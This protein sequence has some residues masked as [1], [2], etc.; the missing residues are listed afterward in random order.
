[1]SIYSRYKKKNWFNL[2]HYF[3]SYSLIVAILINLV[4]NQY[5][6][7]Y[8]IYNLLFFLLLKKNLNSQIFFVNIL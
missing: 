2:L 7:I 6:I 8:L 4:G 5:F 1:M 3:Q